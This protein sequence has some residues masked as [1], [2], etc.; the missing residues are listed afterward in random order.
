MKKYSSTP[1]TINLIVFV[2][3][4][5]GFAFLAVWF[6]F[7]TVPYVWTGVSHAPIDVDR[8]NI[9]LGLYAILGCLGIAGT[10]VSGLGLCRSVVAFR[11]NDDEA[12]RR[13]FDCYFSLGYVLAAAL[14][15]NAGW[16]ILQTTKNFGSGVSIG[17]VVVVY[18]VALILVLVGTNIPLVKVHDADDD[19]VAIGRILLLASLAIGAAVAITMLY[20]ALILSINGDGHKTHKVYLLKDL[21]LAIAPFIGCALASVG[22]RASKK[23]QMLR[24]S[25]LLYM[26]LGV[27]GLGIIAA[28][29][30]TYFTGVNKDWNRSNI[31]SYLEPKFAISEYMTNSVLSFVFGSLIVVAACVLFAVTLRPKKEKAAR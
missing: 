16:L 4:T 25:L 23:G 10:I 21:V 6:S 18:I 29:I 2:L 30:L 20:S 12:V 9:S 3:L 5:A 26:S 11:K 22:L 19:G 28:G 1:R 24:S 31:G 7:L 13:T 8:E 17:F 27:Y 14:F 15:L